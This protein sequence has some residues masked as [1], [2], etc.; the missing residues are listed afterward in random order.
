M[1]A[2]LHNAVL[3][4]ALALAIG[5]STFASAQGPGPT[6]VPTPTPAPQAAPAPAGT[7]TLPGTPQTSPPIPQP[8][9]FGDV[10]KGAT[11]LPGYF[12]LYE[13]D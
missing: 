13:K 1:K 4:P 8:R 12:T 2:S 10:I 3:I 6:P 5:L 7:S 9:P 11:E